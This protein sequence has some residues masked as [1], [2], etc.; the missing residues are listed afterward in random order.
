MDAMKNRLRL[1]LLTLTASMSALTLVAQTA[2][3]QVGESTLAI[4]G[5]STMHDW[6]MT[7]KDV[8][9][10]ADFTLNSDGTPA[11][12]NKLSVALSAESLKSHKDGMDKNAYKALKTDKHKTISFQL[13]NATVQGNTFNTTGN[14]TISGVTQKIDL[15]AVCA[16]QSDKSLRC[17]GTKE[18]KMSDYKVEAP[19]FMFGTIKTGDAITLTFDVKLATKPVSAT[20]N[21]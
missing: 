3:R 13:L 14:L 8:T 11:G 4:A 2:F 9:C 21:E 7:S 17:T 10:Q 18:L 16:V 6:T 20:T 12:L 1:L 5:T 19:S 15:Q